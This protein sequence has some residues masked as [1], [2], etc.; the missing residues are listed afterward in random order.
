MEQVGSLAL[1]MMAPNRLTV[2]KPEHTVPITCGLETQEI[3][4]LDCLKPMFYRQCCRRGS[5]TTNERHQRLS[6]VSGIVLEPQ[7]P[8]IR[9]GIRDLYLEYRT[10]SA[11]HEFFQYTEQSLLTN[12]NIEV[13]S[14]R[15]LFDPAPC[16]GDIQALDSKIVPEDSCADETTC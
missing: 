8:F 5:G 12:I 14:V 6:K 13:V 4:S 3:Y 1:T 7:I 9:L 11:L 2:A 15:V 16:A 10:E